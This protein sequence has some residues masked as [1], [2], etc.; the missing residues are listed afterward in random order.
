MARIIV[1]NRIPEL[2]EKIRN[3]RDQR[4][5]TKSMKTHL[6]KPARDFHED[7]VR[8]FKDKQYPLRRGRAV[9]HT[10]DRRDLIR[11]GQT[12]TERLHPGS[13]PLWRGQQAPTFRKEV[14]QVGVNISFENISEHLNLFLDAI[15]PH[16]I[17][18]SSV[19]KP[20]QFYMGGNLP[21]KPRDGAFKYIKVFAVDHPGKEDYFIYI[22]DIFEQHR[23]KF[24]EAMQEA[25]GNLIETTLRGLF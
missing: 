18:A 3:L 15:G 25:T 21:W 2:T 19:E 12:P 7:I 17:P 13:P 14:R 9:S 10:A 16:S 8:F 22:E 1:N 6:S 24:E 23:S 20:L 11:D 4:K 5:V